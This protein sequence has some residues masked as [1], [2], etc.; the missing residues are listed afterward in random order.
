MAAENELSIRRM[1]QRE[2]DEANREQKRL[3]I[4]QTDLDRRQ[5]ET[6]TLTSQRAQLSSENSSLSQ[7]LERQRW[8]QSL[9]QDPQQNLQQDLS[10]TRQQLRAPAPAGEHGA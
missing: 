8:V 9:Q 4:S 3:I 6:D 10:S 1:Q 7:R 2:L 5:L